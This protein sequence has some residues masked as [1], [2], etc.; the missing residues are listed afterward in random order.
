MSYFIF[1]FIFYFHYSLRHRWV[2]LLLLSLRI[3]LYIYEIYLPIHQQPDHVSVCCCSRVVLADEAVGKLFDCASG[4][5][6][7]HGLDPRWC[8]TPPAQ[9]DLWADH[10]VHLLIL[11]FVGSVN[12]KA[13]ASYEIGSWSILDFF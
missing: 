7:F 3:Y 9:I 10:T 2:S 5:P 1:I 12:V 6:G 11:F 13:R 8:Q 4:C